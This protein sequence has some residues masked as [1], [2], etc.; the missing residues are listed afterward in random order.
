MVNKKIVIWIIVFV[1]V[2]QLA[3][4]LGI[5]PAK[6]EMVHLTEPDFVGQ[7]WVV[8]NE[9]RD[10]SVDV[11]VGGEMA[12]YVTLNTNSLT[13]TSD[14][15]AL[16][17]PYEVHLPLI[18]PPGMSSATIS[19]EEELDGT[20]AN[21]VSS[22]L[23]LKHKILI[24]GEFPD[25]FIEMK[26]NFHD[27][28]DYYELVS[29]VENLGKL[30]INQIQTK[31]YVNDKQQDQQVI[32][33][34]KTSLKKKQNKLL[35]ANLEKQYL[36]QGEFEVLS[37]TTFDDQQM[38]LSKKLLVG[39]PEIEVVYFDKYFIVDKINEYSMDLLNKWNKKVENVYVDVQVLKDGEKVDSFRTKS[40]DIE[41]EVIKRINDFFDTRGKS[42]G[43]YTFDLVVNFWNLY[44]MDTKT[45]HG[46]IVTNDEYE[47]LD[48]A[49][50]QNLY[51]GAAGLGETSGIIT[52]L[53]VLIAVIVLIAIIALV[54]KMMERKKEGGKEEF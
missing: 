7:F 2:M 36:E 44:K 48:T 24:Q 12:Q 25:L 53:W 1:L 35:S 47:E 32:E 9:E 29:E 23:V 28:E 10:F 8:N 38:E 15:D 3:L 43:S 49:P 27:R 46:E 14:D 33:T 40:V 30:D 39:R 31:F 4:A 54:M 20:G 21:V 45:F 52:A 42:V 34:E 5:R 13:F 37:I 17:V 51:G 11:I 19:V 41:G 22:K 18:V 50:P 16:A 26:V 6:T